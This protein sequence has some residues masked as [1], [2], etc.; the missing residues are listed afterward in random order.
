VDTADTLK[1][2][3]DPTRLRLVRLLWQEE[4]SVAELQDILE[5]GQS[6]ISTHLGLLRQGNL[7]TDRRDGKRSYYQVNH[8]LPKAHLKIVEVV[9]ESSNGDELAEQDRQ[10]LNRILAQRQKLSEE[11]FNTIAGRLGRNYCPGRS[12]EAIGHFL[13]K[14]T[15][16]LVVADLGAGE[17]LLA[18]LLARRAKQVY[19]IDNSP[20]MVEVGTELAAKNGFDNLEYKVGDIENV[21]L[22]D[23]SIDLCFL[24][25][26]L[27][28]ANHPQKAL[29][30]A[31]RILKPG[32]QLIV[33][34]LA[35][36]QFEKAR[37]L[38]ADRWLGFPRSTLYQWMKDCGFQEI[39]ASIVARED[40]EPNFE[41]LL[42]SGVK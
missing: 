2:L 8:S 42:A 3:A 4:L 34:D 9:C 24:S 28:H 21:P 17:G 10:N 22:G 11:F 27:H 15:P 32:G 5:M 23:N 12:W 19:C 7:V 36:H 41:T 14:L 1:L 16:P 37:E 33:I 29:A 18:Q 35:E 39:D 26:A 40:I 25:Q 6:R 13:L 20:R 30:E 31:Y 38:Y